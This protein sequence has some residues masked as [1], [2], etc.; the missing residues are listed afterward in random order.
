MKDSAFRVAPLGAE[1]DRGAFHCGEEAFDRYFQTQATQDI[2][3]RIANCFVAV[4]TANGVVA[5]YYTIAAASIPLVE[6]PAQEIKHLPRYPTLPAVRIGRLAVHEGFQSRGLGGALLVDA[7]R[8]VLQAPTA[9][10]ALLVDAKT[11]HAVSF[12]R[13]YLFRALVGKPATLFL[14]LATAGKALRS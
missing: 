12:Y 5:G 14:P 3:R 8:R 9:I 1:H 6:L 2:R 11:D 13:R 10:C 4:E 7:T